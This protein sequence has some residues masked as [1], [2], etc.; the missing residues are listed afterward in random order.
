[1][2][3]DVGVC[4]VACRCWC[5]SDCV[6]V[7]G[8]VGLRVGVGVCLVLLGIDGQAA[9]R[10]GHEGATWH[11][12][13]CSHPLTR[14][15]QILLVPLLP[16]RARNVRR[17]AQAHCHG[18]GMPSPQISSPTVTF[19]GLLPPVVNR[20]APVTVCLCDGRSTSSPASMRA[21]RLRGRRCSPV[22]AISVPFLLPFGLCPR[23]TP[24]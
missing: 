21:T 4:Q 19:D 9:W 16:Q 3:V 12:P 13:P 18:Q 17:D 14:T 8:C 23:L 6:L 5:V 2:R 7:L 1:M 11:A 24:R 22:S 10:A 15:L 20:F